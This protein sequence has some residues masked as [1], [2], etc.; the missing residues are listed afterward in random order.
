MDVGLCSTSAAPA[1]AGEGFELWSGSVVS[2]QSV[3][4]RGGGPTPYVSRRSLLGHPHASVWLTA[5]LERITSSWNISR[6]T[7][8]TLDPDGADK[9]S[10]PA[11][12][13]RPSNDSGGHMALDDRID[14]LASVEGHIPGIQVR[15][16][17]LDG[18]I[19]VAL[20]SLQGI[21]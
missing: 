20:L 5:T 16:H 15:R 21:V 2:R 17:R 4:Y 18:A 12:K 6:L 10:I 8:A 14:A 19:R 13:Q 3:Q 9:K 11:T 1:R 7:T